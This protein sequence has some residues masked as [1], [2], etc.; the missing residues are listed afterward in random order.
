MSSVVISS[1]A[2]GAG[3]AT[4]ELAAVIAVWAKVDYASQAAAIFIAAVLVLQAF[5]LGINSIR[6]HG[7]IVELD[8]AGVDLQQL[9]QMQRGAGTR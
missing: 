2:T 7:G 1:G 3:A 9:P 6:S 8:Q 4:A 5:E